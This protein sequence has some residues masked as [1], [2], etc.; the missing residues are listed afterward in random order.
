VSDAKG[1]IR[2]LLWEH[3]RPSLRRIDDR[4]LDKLAE[5][6]LDIAGRAL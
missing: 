3:S 6:I 5:R 4:A 1:D 2:A